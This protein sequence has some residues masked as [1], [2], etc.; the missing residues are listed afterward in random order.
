MGVDTS[1]HPVFPDS[2]G[3]MILPGVSL[4]PGALLP[5]YIFEDRYRRM[6]GQALGSGRM[7]AIAHAGDDGEVAATGGL[8]FVRAC[9]SKPDGTSNLILQGVGRVTFSDVRLSPFPRAVIRLLPDEPGDPEVIQSIRRELDEICRHVRA[10]GIALPQGFE[11]YLKQVHAGGA[12]ADA[13]A[14]ALITD[15]VEQRGLLEETSVVV[16]MERLLRCLIR[17]LHLP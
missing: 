2:V 11:T 7:F 16:R 1:D 14:A 12:Y 6:L 15:P 8:G 13:L 4:F 5:L 3:L 9:V 10:S 17:Q